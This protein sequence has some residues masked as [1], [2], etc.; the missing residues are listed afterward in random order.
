MPFSFAPPAP[1]PAVSTTDVRFDFTLSD[2]DVVTGSHVVLRILDVRGREV[3]RVLGA[4]TV[5]HQRLVW[6]GRSNSGHLAAAGVYVGQL[7]VGD[8]SAERKFVR[9]P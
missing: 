6:N 9:L 4:P 5:G 8:Q 1:N 2:E 7:L 3:A